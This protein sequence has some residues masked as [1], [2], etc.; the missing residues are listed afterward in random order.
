MKKLFQ[1]MLV[2]ALFITLSACTKQV[3]PTKTTTKSTEMAKIEDDIH[4]HRNFKSIKNFQ[5]ENI[6]GHLALG[7][8]KKAYLNRELGEFV[9]FRDT[10]ALQATYRV[11]PMSDTKKKVTSYEFPVSKNNL[12]KISVHPSYR[13]DFSI[14]QE[15]IERVKTSRKETSFTLYGYKTDNGDL[16]LTDGDEEQ[17]EVYVY[18]IE[19][20]EKLSVISEKADIYQEPSANSKIISSKKK[21]EDITTISTIV[22]DGEPKHN[23]WYE[24]K[25]NNQTGY[26]RW[27]DLK[28]VSKSSV[29][30]PTKSNS[31]DLDIQQIMNKNFSSLAGIWVNAAGNELVINPDGT[32]RTGEHLAVGHQSPAVDIVTLTIGNAPVALAIFPIGKENPYGGKSD[33]SKP[34]IALVQSFDAITSEDYYYR[35]SDSPTEAKKSVTK[36]QTT[37]IPSSNDGV[38]VEQVAQG[39]MAS[40]AGTW[41]NGYGTQWIIDENGRLSTGE[42]LGIAPEI[43]GDDGLHLRLNYRSVSTPILLIPIGLAHGESDVTK[44][45]LTIAND[46][47]TLSS[48]DYFYKK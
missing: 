48:K 15:E 33:V 3:Q 6:Y 16:V 36:T 13:F 47:N 22:G 23:N 40:L 19:T 4:W 38:M 43:Q 18:P 41:V 46:I 31:A 2:L 45:R 9:A 21:G 17:P 37:T 35:K 34:R 42:I 11:H 26:I 12:N 1:G 29:S 24:V 30:E 5:E 7:P 39:K 10:R 32:M 28:K 25:L 44:N 8:N 14:S 20:P 27:E